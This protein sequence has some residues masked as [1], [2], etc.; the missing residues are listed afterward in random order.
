[1]GFAVARAA[2]EAGADVTLVAGPTALATPYGVH[3]L[4]VQ[5]ARQMHDVVMSK[6]EGQDVFIAVAAVADWRVA[7]TSERKLKKKDADDV[8][9]LV[10]AQNPDILAAVAASPNRPY[11]VGFAAESENLL[12]HGEQKRRK[13]N[14]PLLVGNIGPQTFGLD[15]N[16]LVR[17]DEAGHTAL[18]RGP[19]RELA[20]RLI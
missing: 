2:R 6:L 11:C 17:F 13:K 20:R 16:E 8:P 7:N 3:R 15:H 9:H 1:M 10:F 14:I 4:N 18:P 19:K 12:E 5:T